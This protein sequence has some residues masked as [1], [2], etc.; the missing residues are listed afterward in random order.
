[1]SGMPAPAAQPARTVM[2]PAVVAPRPE[3]PRRRGL[4]IVVILIIALCGSIYLARHRR[5]SP[6]TQRSI[7]LAGI[8]TAVIAP[9]AVERTLRLTGAT[10]AANYRSLIA[11]R[12]IG[13]RSDHGRDLSA[14]TGS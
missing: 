12:L 3:K 9:G 14:A 8:R 10:A 11:P 5:I 2:R 7:P 4:W 6:R 1:M 13:S